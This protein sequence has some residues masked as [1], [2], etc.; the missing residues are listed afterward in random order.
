VVPEKRIVKNRIHFDLG[1]SGGR[2]V[3]L[4][5]RRARVAAEVDRLVGWALHCCGWCR[6]RASTTTAS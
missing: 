2:S 1:V 5:A 3:P 4:E 6:R